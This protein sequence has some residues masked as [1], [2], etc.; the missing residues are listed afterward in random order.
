MIKRFIIAILT[1]GVVFGGIAW[2]NWFRDQ[3]IKAAFAPKDPPPAT[4]STVRATPESWRRKIEAIGTLQ[5]IHSVDVAPQ[6]SGIVREIQFEAGQRVNKGDVLVKLDDN[7]LQAELRRLEAAKN[8]SKLT[9]ER[10]RQLSEK[11]FSAQATVDQA[12]ATL[13][14]NDADIARARALIDQKTIRA[15]FTGELGVR[16]VNLGQY[17][18]PGTKLVGLQSLDALYANLTFPEQRMADLR[19]GQDVRI[20]VDAFKGREFMG[21][22]TTI[23]PQ[24]DQ[25]NRTVL[26]QAT[27]PNPEKLLRPG[28]FLNGEVLLERKDDVVT[29]PKT[30]ID[31]SLY[32]DSVYVVTAGETD[33][34]GNTVRRVERRAVT[35]GEQHG[36]RVAVTGVKPDEEV[37]TAGQIKLRN[38]APVVIDNTIALKPSRELLVK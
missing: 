29:V 30:A 3:M 33:A 5:A 32:G 1:L 19:I 15:P 25:N 24:L 37:V 22:I 4:V 27:V 8:M 10:Q 7:V 36:Q 6:I 34:N 38:N 2:F 14:Q 21:K 31:F 35:L 9:Y 13:D 23:D 17:V 26:V 20:W 16:H 18:D 28:M 12:K 11:Q